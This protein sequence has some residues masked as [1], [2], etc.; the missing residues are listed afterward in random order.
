M[1]L[2]ADTLVC[3]VHE[4]NIIGTTMTDTGIQTNVTQLCH[5]WSNGGTFV[6]TNGTL[7]FLCSWCSLLHYKMYSNLLHGFGVFH[8]CYPLLLIT[9]DQSN[10]RKMWVRERESV[11]V[12]VRRGDIFVQE[13]VKWAL[14][15]NK[16]KDLYFFWKTFSMTMYQ[17]GKQL[18]LLART[19]HSIVTTWLPIQFK[20]NW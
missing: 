12:C 4:Q 2:W 15:N 5:W 17:C 16:R 3:C 6:M 19:R 9:G 11:C 20:W 10:R 18:S 13:L 1:I 8:Q 14:P 7:F